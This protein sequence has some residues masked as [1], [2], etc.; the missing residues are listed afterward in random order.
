MVISPVFRVVWF[1]WLPIYSKF[2]WHS[3]SLRQCNHISIYFV[4]FGCIFP[5]H[6]S[7]VILL[8]VFNGVGGCLCPIYSSTIL[9]YTA[10]HSMMY[11]AASSASV[12]YFMM[13]LIMWAMLIIAPFF[14]GIVALLDKKK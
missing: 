9:V 1:S 5:L 4:G 7:Y 12:A 8:Y 2:F 11:S 10:S 3:L 6:T 13:C 14:C